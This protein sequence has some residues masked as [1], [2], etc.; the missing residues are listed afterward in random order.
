MPELDERIAHYIESIASPVTGEEA[1]SRVPR[2]L[3]RRRIRTWR[4]AIGA[5]LAAA[6]V[7]AGLVFASTRGATSQSPRVHV[8]DTPTIAPVVPPR[9]AHPTPH[10]GEPVYFAPVYVP[11]GYAL[12]RAQ[13]G[14]APGKGDTANDLEWTET[15]TWVRFNS[16]HDQ[17]LATLQINRGPRVDSRPDSSHRSDRPHRERP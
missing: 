13:G 17:A 8:G 16:A 5:V 14:D 2:A 6:C 3:P 11:P 10:E 12:I 1:R 7:A 15:Q 4:V 9:S